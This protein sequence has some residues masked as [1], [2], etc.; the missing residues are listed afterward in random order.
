MWPPG[1]RRTP[2]TQRPGKQ[3][4]RAETICTCDHL[5]PHVN[6]KRDCLKDSV[7]SGCDLKLFPEENS[8]HYITITPT[9]TDRRIEF[10][11]NVKITGRLD[12]LNS[13]FPYLNVFSVDC[14]HP[15]NKI[16]YLLVNKINPHEVCSDVTK[17]TGSAIQLLFPPYQAKLD[18]SNLYRKCGQRWVRL[19]GHIGF[20]LHGTRIKKWRNY[21][22][23]SH[24]STTHILLIF[25][26][27]GQATLMKDKAHHFVLKVHIFPHLR[28][29]S[30]H[31]W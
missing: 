17:N 12:N 1:G 2:W 11:I 27:F 5:C 3:W 22:L 4:C 26:V 9:R 10:A 24:V 19:L 18:E 14:P 28:K 31:V 15:T 25:G 16:N 20:H 30:A 6:R 8:W 13:S 29:S 7:G 23:F 21:P